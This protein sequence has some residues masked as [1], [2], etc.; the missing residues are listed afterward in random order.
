V[1]EGGIAME[2]RFL[3]IMSAIAVF[4]LL[5]AGL[6]FAI[7]VWTRQQQLKLKRA[8]NTRLLKR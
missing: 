4:T 8:S 1:N 2:G 5:T 3:E 6:M 7:D